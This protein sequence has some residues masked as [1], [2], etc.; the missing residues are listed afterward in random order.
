MILAIIVAMAIVAGL[1]IAD[2]N[3]YTRAMRQVDR[4]IDKI[5]IEVLKKKLEESK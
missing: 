2:H 4:D 5:F 3:G 1:L